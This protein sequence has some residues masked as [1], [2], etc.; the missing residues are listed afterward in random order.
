[1]QKDLKLIEG[2]FVPVY[3]NNKG[4]RLVSARELFFVLRGKETKTK[5]GDWIKDRLNRYIFVE[6]EDFIGFSLKNEKPNGGR[7]TKEYY[8][9]IDTA[10]EICMIENNEIGRKIRKYF[11]E[12][13]K[14]YRKIVE[15]PQNIFD[16]MRLALDQIEENE[17]RLKSV[18][19]ISKQNKE[20]IEY[21]I[22]Y[23]RNAKNGKKG[24]VKERKYKI[25]NVCYKIKI[26]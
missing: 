7:P 13:E 10:K 5:F 11:I 17:K 24:E 3:E 1:M 9:T 22:I 25:E 14:R 15:S 26:L 16:V 18:E 2:E 6:N 20:E 12:V 19:N 23:E 4:E 21:K 8:L